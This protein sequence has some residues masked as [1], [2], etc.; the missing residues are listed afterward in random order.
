[1]FDPIILINKLNY[2]RDNSVIIFKV[3]IKNIFC[4]LDVGLRLNF[5]A[6]IKNLSL[7]DF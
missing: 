7:F 2:L 6:V 1:M 5:N 3:H 4:D